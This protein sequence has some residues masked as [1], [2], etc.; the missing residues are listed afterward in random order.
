MVKYKTKV[1]A[2]W[3]KP[4]MVLSLMLIAAGL[5]VSPFLV[6]VGQILLL[7][8]FI[9]EGN[10]NI[11][12]QKLKANKT[13][14]L[15]MLLPFIH[16]VWL[17][18]TTDFAFAA[19]DLKIKIPL[20]IIPLILGLSNPLSAIQ[21]RAVLFSFVF[22]SLSATAVTLAVMLHI[23]NIEITDIR[24]VSFI[25]SHIRYSLMLVL[26]VFIVAYYTV[27]N[28]H[29]L[30]G[31][32]KF[33]V[34]LLISWFIY[35]IYYLQSATAW[36]VLVVVPAITYVI[37]FKQ[38]NNR[39]V[40]NLL[41]TGLM[42]VLLSFSAMVSVGFYHFFLK[43]ENRELLQKTK[44]IEGH[45]YVKHKQKFL[46]NENGY[47]IFSNISLKEL[48]R[49]WP[50]YSNYDFYGKCDDGKKL[51][52]VLIRYMSS[53]GLTKDAEGLRHLSETDIRNIEQGFT[54]VVYSTKFK[55]Y[56]KVYEM[57][58]DLANYTSGGNPNKKSLAQRLEYLKTSRFIVQH[59]FWW[60]V[61]TGD[62]KMAFNDMYTKINTKLDK[63]NRHRAHNQFLTFLIVFG[64]YGFVAAMVGLFGPW[65]YTKNRNILFV[66]FMFLIFISMLNED[67]LETQAGVTFYIFFYALLVFNKNALYD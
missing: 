19:R 17:L 2:I 56:I 36:V 31:W 61:G 15:F 39:T 34:G 6:S 35:F 37:Y 8:N 51:R 30:D 11:K 55:P 53:R 58:W 54:S 46:G 10:Y 62:L 22:G 59:N 57:V 45:V 23:Y 27:K 52:F 65:I 3:G 13:L 4:F 40:R 1:V 33:G 28:Y 50:K 24:D 49:D 5:P 20:L 43:S 64:V 29:K 25:I 32:D 14:W 60:G 12:F 47:S 26:T 21:L 16:I 41:G 7:L 38:I 66:S 63:E 48:K 18:N 67:T 44:T 9:V 42:L